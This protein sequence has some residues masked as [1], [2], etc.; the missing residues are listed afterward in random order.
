MGFNSSIHT[1]PGFKAY[2]VTW[3]ALVILAAASVIIV[4]LDTGVAGIVI[5]FIIASVKALLILYFFMHLGYETRFFR[6]AFVLPFVAMAFFL[7][8]TF[9]DIFYR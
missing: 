7:G 8:F 2:I 4:T 3:I 5:A 9:L 6:L 1:E